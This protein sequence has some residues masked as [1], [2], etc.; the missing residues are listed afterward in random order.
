MRNHAWCSVYI[1]YFKK[2]DQIM[3]SQES[4][5][6]IDKVIFSYHTKIFADKD[7]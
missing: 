4:V 3:T 5:F 1:K 7:S 6:Q 2:I